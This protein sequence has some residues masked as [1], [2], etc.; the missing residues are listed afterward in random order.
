MDL[1]NVRSERGFSLE[2]WD[3]Q[4]GCWFIVNDSCSTHL[5]CVEEM[6]RLA[7]DEHG[8]PARYRIVETLTQEFDPK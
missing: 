1:V 2:R 6:G 5:E 7:T 3:D 8:Q 4:T